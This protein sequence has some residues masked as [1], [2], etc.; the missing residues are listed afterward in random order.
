MSSLEKMLGLLDVF[1]SEQPIWSSEDLIGHLGSPASTCYRYLKVL[2]TSGY[3]ARVANGSYVLEQEGEQ[4]EVRR[5]SL[6][7]GSIGHRAGVLADRVDRLA[8]RVG[9]K[10]GARH[11]HR[12]L[13]DRVAPDARHG[14]EFV[15]VHPL[16]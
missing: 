12:G 7:S 15:A 8:E 5:G 4:G 11:Q 13:A 1:T 3:L 14:A 16:Q 9:G 6:P 10:V 2:H